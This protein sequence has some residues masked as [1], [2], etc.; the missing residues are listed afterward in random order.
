LQT[1]LQQCI[2]SASSRTADQKDFNLRLCEALLSANIP[3]NKV[4]NHKFKQFLETFCKKNIPHESTLR[5]NYVCSIYNNVIREIKS[6]IK[7]Q[8]LYIIVDETTDVRGRYIANLLVGVLNENILPKSFLIS[9]K[10]LKKTNSV[11]IV[12]FVN[13]SLMAFFAPDILPTE[14]I[15]LLITDAAAYMI[16]AGANLNIFYKN[17]IHVTCLAHGINRVAEEIRCQFPLVNSLISNVKKSL[18]KHRFESKCIKKSCR[19]SPCLQN[20]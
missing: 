11:E 12:R 4:Q 16:K 6:H 13:E 20:Q 19:T 18:S 14:K 7:D 3:L 17:L 8:F 5:K 2:S 15:L 10:E 1:S 9:T